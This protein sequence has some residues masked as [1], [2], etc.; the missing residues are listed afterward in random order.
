MF[1]YATAMQQDRPRYVIDRT[2]YNLSDFDKEFDK[3]SR[4]FPIGE[5][6]KKLFR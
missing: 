2:A 1:Q 6:V 4:Q 5:K 3:K